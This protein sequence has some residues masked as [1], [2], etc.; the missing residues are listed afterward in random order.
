MAAGACDFVAT[1]DFDGLLF[2]APRVLNRLN[3]RVAGSSECELWDADAIERLAGL[4]RRAL[5][6]AAFL[7][8]CVY[9]MRNVVRALSPYMP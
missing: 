7:N 8:G 6:V 5:I 4:D 3:L 2:G 1:T 9:D